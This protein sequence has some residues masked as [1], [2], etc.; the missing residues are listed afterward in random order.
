MRAFCNTSV[1]DCREIFNGGFTNLHS[2][3]GVAGVL[4]ADRQLDCNDA[5]DGD[6]TL[7]LDVPQEVFA[8]Y[9]CDAPGYRAAIVA[10][11][12]L[13]GLDKPRL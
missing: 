1:A 13:N 10:A 5:V 7:C 12:V 6:V 2:V 3:G 11:D 4:L 9:A 8:T